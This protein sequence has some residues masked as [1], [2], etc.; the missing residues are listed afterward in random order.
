MLEGFCQAEE[1]IARADLASNRGPGKVSL[2]VRNEC[3]GMAAAAGGPPPMLRQVAGAPHYDPAPIP[4]IL[5][6]GRVLDMS[7]PY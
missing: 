5:G 1:S 7:A 6:V 3:L 4:I 2:L